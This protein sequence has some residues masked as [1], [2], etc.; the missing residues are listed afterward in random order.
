MYYCL[1]SN[2]S[3][4]ITCIDVN[5]NNS[6]LEVDGNVVETYSVYSDGACCQ[7]YSQSDQNPLCCIVSLNKGIALFVLKYGPTSENRKSDSHL[8]LV[9]FHEPFSLRQQ[10]KSAIQWSMAFGP[11]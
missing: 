3:V 10:L 7:T 4:A 5:L 1:N 11:S 6:T 8:H 9:I 2:G